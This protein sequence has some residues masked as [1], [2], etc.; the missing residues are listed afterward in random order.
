V[1]NT[2]QDILVRTKRFALRI[3]SLYASLPNDPASRTMGLQALRSATSV[4]AHVREGKH[5]RSAAEKLS[6]VSVASQELEETRY[7]LE[8]MNES[9]VCNGTISAEIF[10][11]AD[12]LIAILFAS[13]R[14]LRR[15]LG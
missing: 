3:V 11:E 7:W 9:F 5:S 6:K 4:G 13:K 15:H 10:Q 2:A 8:L 12:E 14:T 1:E